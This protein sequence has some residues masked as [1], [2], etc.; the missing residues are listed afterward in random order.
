[1]DAWPTKEKQVEPKVFFSQTV[2]GKG[3]KK[4][5]TGKGIKKAT[6]WSQAW[7]RRKGKSGKIKRRGRKDKWRQMKRARKRFCKRQGKMS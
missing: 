2:A 5:G 1:M 7:T 4:T 3:A 6:E